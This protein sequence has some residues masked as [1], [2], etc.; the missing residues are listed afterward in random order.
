MS[1]NREAMPVYRAFHTQLD[2]HNFFNHTLRGES[3][4]NLRSV[5]NQF[6]KKQ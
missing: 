3:E 1:F 5:T 4:V 6:N 2:P